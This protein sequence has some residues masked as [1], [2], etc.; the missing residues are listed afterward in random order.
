ML[1]PS[2]QCD[3]LEHRCWLAERLR[4]LDKAWKSRFPAGGNLLGSCKLIDWKF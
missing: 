1:R 2:G 4:A 3:V